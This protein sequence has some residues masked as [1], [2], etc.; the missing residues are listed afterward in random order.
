MRERL[1][2]NSLHPLRLA[3]LGNWLRD[4]HAG[5]LRVNPVGDYRKLSWAQGDAGVH[6]SDKKGFSNSQLEWL[7]RSPDLREP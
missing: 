4:L 2:R 3:S 5:L 7:L 1:G 6:C